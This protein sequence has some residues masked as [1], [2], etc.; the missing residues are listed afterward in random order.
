MPSAQKSVARK[1]SAKTTAARKT[2]SARESAAKPSARPRATEAARKRCEEN[3]R[4]VVRIKEALE[5]TQREMTAIRGNL[6]AGGRDLRKDVAKLLRD[7]RR[8]VEKMN[9]TVRRDMQQLQK[10]LSQAAKAK[11]SGGARKAPR[12]GARTARRGRS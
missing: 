3:G 1:T 8:D 10:D 7:A 5:M 11:S 2:S 6:Q 4:A 9:T 12:T